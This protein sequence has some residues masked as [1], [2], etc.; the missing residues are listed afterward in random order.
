MKIVLHGGNCCGI[1]H[2]T[3]LSNYPDMLLA[4][5]RAVEK[6]SEGTSFGHGFAGAT[7]DMRSKHQGVADED[8]FNEKAPS[9]SYA[10]RLRRFIRFLKRV[11]PRHLVEIVLNGYQVAW[12]PVLEKIE[13]K[14]VTEFKNGNTGSTLTVWH[15]TLKG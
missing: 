4:A 9:E 2:I 11:R 5:R 14:K 12:Y 1:K 13:F 8:F 10:A 7:N 3:N 15:L 6:G